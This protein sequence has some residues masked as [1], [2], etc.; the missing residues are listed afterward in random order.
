MFFQQDLASAPEFI[1]SARLTNQEGREIDYAVYTSA[2]SL[3]HFVSLGTI[4]RLNTGVLDSHCLHR[5]Y[6]EI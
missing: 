3:L 1:K 5:R 4:E 6:R 2:A